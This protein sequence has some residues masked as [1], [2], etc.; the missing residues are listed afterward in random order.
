MYS[1]ARRQLFEH[2]ISTTRSSVLIPSYIS[3]S[4]FYRYLYIPHT[5][6]RGTYP[7]PN[8]KYNTKGYLFLLTPFLLACSFAPTFPGLLTPFLL[9]CRLFHTLIIFIFSNRSLKTLSTSNSSYNIVST[10]L[11]TKFFSS[12]EISLLTLSF[13][14]FQPL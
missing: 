2:L 7:R 8:V 5:S 1:P 12:S 9:F 4:T 3:S 14:E 10:S 6:A 11:T 13:L